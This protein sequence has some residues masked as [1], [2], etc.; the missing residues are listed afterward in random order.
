M[1][2]VS[3]PRLA[4]RRSATGG[5]WWSK[6]V[7]RAVEEAAFSQT[8]LKRGRALARAGAVGSIS[9]TEGSAVAAVHE[10]DDT[11]T[12]TVTVPVLDDVGAATFVEVVAAE[13]GRIGAL[14]AGQLPHPFVEAIEEAGVE[15]LPYGGELGAACTCDAWL[16]PCPH[17]LAVL[18]QVAWLI[19]AEPFVLT[20]LRG[21]SREVVLQRLH[22]M[23]LRP[24]DGAAT[25]SD[26]A[27][28]RTDDDLAVAVDAAD[29]AARA[30]EL[31]EQGRADDL[32]L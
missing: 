30:V 18:T 15:L 27:L 14:L 1:G 32:T 23:T 7:L 26:E 25:G 6:A 16:D 10:R 11:F 4:P 9:V 31:F 21:L 29:R 5:T 20:H 17:A 8:D 3:H 2:S 22:D 13:S 19:Q 12:V 28:G 24:G